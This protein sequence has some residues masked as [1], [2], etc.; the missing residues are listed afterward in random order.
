MHAS[1]HQ[2]IKFIRRPWYLGPHK[3]STLS[4]WVSYTHVV[5]SH[6]QHWSR[7][8]SSSASAP[9]DRGGDS[10]SE[11]PDAGHRLPPTTTHPTP[12]HPGLTPRALPPTGASR[13]G[14]VPLGSGALLRPGARMQGWLLANFH[15]AATLGSVCPQKLAHLWLTP[16]S[17]LPHYNT[18][19]V[20][21]AVNYLLLV[22]PDRLSVVCVRPWVFRVSVA[23]QNIAN[24]IVT[25]GPLVLASSVLIPHH[26]LGSAVLAVACLARLSEVD[27]DVINA[28]QPPHR[29]V[30][31]SSLSPIPSTVA[32]HYEISRDTISSDSTAVSDCGGITHLISPAPPLLPPVLTVARLATAAPSGS[33]K[34]F[35]NAVLSPAKA[36]P[37]CPRQPFRL[38]PAPLPL[39][40]LPRH[41]PPGL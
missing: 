22:H 2:S 38:P 15:S 29:P 28:A 4:R 35:L 6:G 5:P 27:D 32:G 13:T 7:M 1:N 9:C 30:V 18:H 8:A 16:S 41:G 33:C 20:R 23:S 12:T 10:S 36:P 40:S 39:F 34:A 21:N 26:S 31:A 19:F 24:V 17:L 14:A 25:R 11:P 37:R 3:I